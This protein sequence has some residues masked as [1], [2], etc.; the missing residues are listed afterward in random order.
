[1]GSATVAPQCGS[2]HHK[3]VNSVGMIYKQCNSSINEELTTEK[4]VNLN[5]KIVAKLVLKV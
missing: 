2:S 1:M 5:F 4:I 3:T